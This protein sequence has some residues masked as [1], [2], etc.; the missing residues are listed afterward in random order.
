MSEW[1]KEI[2]QTIAIIYLIIMALS[3]LYN[4]TPLGKD[5]TDKP[6]WGGGRSG[7][8][9]I[10]D[11][12]TGCHYLQTKDGGITPRLDYEGKPICVVPR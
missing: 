11:H 5:D 1:I 3:F 9:L 4:L 6:G 12:A 2:I 10:I 7:V 8:K